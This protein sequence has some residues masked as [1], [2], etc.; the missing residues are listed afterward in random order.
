MQE[1]RFT[2]PSQGAGMQ[3]SGFR[4]A[5]ALHGGMGYSLIRLRSSDPTESHQIIVTKGLLFFYIFE[6]TL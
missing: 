3:I 5:S 6:I 2:T 1:C 4:N